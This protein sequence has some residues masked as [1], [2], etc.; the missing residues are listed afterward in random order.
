MR[1]VKRKRV[2]SVPFKLFLFLYM[3]LLGTGIYFGLRYLNDYLD[4][5]ERTRPLTALNSYMERLDAAHLRQSASDFFDRLDTNV[6][7]EEI[8]LPA[9]WRQVEG[10]T[11]VRSYGEGID[12]ATE[13]V[14]SLK[15]DGETRGRVTL[16]PGGESI[17]GLTP[18]VVS[19]EVFFL[20]SFLL[21]AELTVP[22]DC[23]VTCNGVTLGEEYITQSD[24]HY[25]LLEEFYGEYDFPSRVTYQVKNCVGQLELEV[26]NA[27]G[28]VMDEASLT[29]EAYT[30]NCTGEEKAQAEAFIKKYVPLYVRF[31]SGRQGGKSVYNDL[32]KLVVPDS[33][34]RSRLSQ[35]LDGLA[36]A[37][38]A[39]DEVESIAV[40]DLMNIGEGRYVCSFT[41]QVN[42][43]NKRGQT[44]LTTSNAK[45]LL[46]STDKGLLAS[47]LISF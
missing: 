20:D 11:P 47:E 32:I 10:C 35:A 4:A 41:Y 39:K 24:I 15:K 22:D 29:E 37:S 6:C 19:E 9:M 2:F 38:S 45:L 8:S 46:V 21:E 16:T 43:T 25:A 3:V 36:W 30:D 34:L 26:R 13:Q 23:T 44:T 14:Y 33:D 5:Y 7:P 18:W 12:S 17:M 31:L 40:N 27:E 42:T 28:Q 1:K